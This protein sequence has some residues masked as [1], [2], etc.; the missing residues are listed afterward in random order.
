MQESTAAQLHEGACGAGVGSAARAAVQSHPPPLLLPPVLSNVALQAVLPRLKPH[1]A[2][3]IGTLE[4]VAAVAAEPQYQFAV[5][6]GGGIRTGAEATSETKACIWSEEERAEAIADL[7]RTVDE[8]QAY[9]AAKAAERAA[10]KKLADQRAAE[11]R[12]ETDRWVKE[13]RQAAARQAK[14]AREAA[15][16]RAA[17]AT[18][19][20]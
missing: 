16:L 7:W 9:W 10:A 11:Q 20:E 8:T 17:R 1:D 12:R 3:D 4:A 2:G 19:R 15:A 14:A 13:F 6:A 5:E 18:Q